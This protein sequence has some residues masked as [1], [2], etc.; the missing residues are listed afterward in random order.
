MESNNKLPIGLRIPDP[1]GPKPNIHLTLNPDSKSPKP[2]LGQ[3]ETLV[4]CISRFSIKHK[5]LIQHSSSILNPLLSRTFAMAPDPNSA[6]GSGAARDD[7]S[8][9]AS[10]DLKKKDDKKDEDLVSCL[11]CVYWLFCSILCIF[12]D[13]D[14]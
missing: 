2:F 6:S 11:I 4:S 9:K 7:A 10:K 5:N 12:G 8:L 3:N 13:F 1:T 14:V